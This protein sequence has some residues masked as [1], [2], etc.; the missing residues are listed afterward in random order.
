M[1]SKYVSIAFA[2]FGIMCGMFGFFTEVYNTTIVIPSSFY[3][4]LGMLSL[5]AAI[6]FETMRHKSI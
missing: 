6:Y 3:L 2:V 4:Q 1:K 5:L